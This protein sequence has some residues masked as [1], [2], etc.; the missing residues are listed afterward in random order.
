MKFTRV[1]FN[2][3]FLKRR[4]QALTQ[5]DEIIVLRFLLDHELASFKEL[6]AVM[7]RGHQFGYRILA[8]MARKLM[9][10]PTSSLNME[11]RLSPV[12]R[13][14]IQNIFRD[15]QYN[16]GFASLFGDE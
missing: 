9:I 15:D 2:E 7:Q 11:W 14:D 4:S 13:T 3:E 5:L 1:F 6:C 12:L 10:E 16:F 8:E